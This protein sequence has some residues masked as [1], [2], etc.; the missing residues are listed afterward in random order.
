MNKIT[1]YDLKKLG[2][3]IGDSDDIYV[4]S[5]INQKLNSGDILGAFDVVSH[6]M[7]IQI[8]SLKDE[9]EELEDDLDDA[10]IRLEDVKD[11]LFYAESAKED[12]EERVNYL[13]DILNEHNISY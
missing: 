12:A 3:A 8:E 2:L 6:A 1:I 7:N 13:E 5:E 4:V 10:D 11:D 9:I